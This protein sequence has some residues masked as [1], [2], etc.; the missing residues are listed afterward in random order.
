MR[1]GLQAGFLMTLGL[2]VE[3]D[4]MDLLDIFCLSPQILLFIFSLFTVD[5][6]ITLN[7]MSDSCLFTN[8]RYSLFNR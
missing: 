1:S 8:H 5:H 7:T 6:D 4:E 3:L 2:D